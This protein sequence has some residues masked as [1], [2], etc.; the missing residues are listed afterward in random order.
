[1]STG[2][3]SSLGGILGCKVCCLSLLSDGLR[4]QSSTPREQGSGSPLLRGWRTSHLLYL[5][6]SAC[7]STS[8]DMH[9]LGCSK[10]AYCTLIH[11]WLQTC[12]EFLAHELLRGNKEWPIGKALEAFGEVRGR[13]SWLYPHDTDAD[14]SLSRNSGRDCVYK[15]ISVAFESNN[16]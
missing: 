4:R 10:N 5:S 8:Q 6:S 12:E 11:I 3:H 16:I 9:S 14:A 1:M 15:A 13:R 2:C 7:A